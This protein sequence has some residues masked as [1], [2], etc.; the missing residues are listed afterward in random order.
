MYSC[1]SL[2]LYAGVIGLAYLADPSKY[3]SVIHTLTF[4]SIV[5]LDHNASATVVT[6]ALYA[7]M[8]VVYIT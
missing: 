2:L 8:H 5:K 4:Q 1:N 6:I 3:V 7:C